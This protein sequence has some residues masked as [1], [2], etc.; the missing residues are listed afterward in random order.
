VLGSRGHHFVAN[1]DP[2]QP[3]T[4]H[5][6][7]G[8]YVASVFD[9]VHDSGYSTAFF[10]GKDKFDVFRRSWGPFGARDVTGADDGTN[11]IDLVWI[12]EDMS[13]LVGEFLGA[14]G[15]RHPTYAFLHLRQ[16]DTTGHADTWDLTPGSRYLAA[17]TEVDRQLGRIL[18][19]IDNDPELRGH[20]ALIL[21]ADH[22]GDL[23]TTDHVLVPAVGLVQSG[24]VPFYVWGAG[25]HPGAD[26]YALNPSTRL[27]PGATSPDMHGPQPI[28]NGEA[29]NLALELLGLP[30]IPGSSI[31]ARRDLAVTVRETAGALLATR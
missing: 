14:L 4:L 1:V 11:K 21:T 8:K 29:G 23:G 3:G 26:L 9:V 18:A 25:V 31:N 20:T 15:V 10:A 19:H 6:L 12:E 7:R 13:T 27:D 16:P 2:G 5:L 17:V 24:I 30:P 22:A 28:R